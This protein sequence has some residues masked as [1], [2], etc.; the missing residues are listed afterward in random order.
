L[1]TSSGGGERARVSGPKAAKAAGSMTPRKARRHDMRQPR[2]SDRAAGAPKFFRRGPER[3][4]AAGGCRPHGARRA[5]ARRDLTFSFGGF[6]ET[7]AP[8]AFDK[9]LPIL[10]RAAI[11]EAVLGGF[12]TL[13]TSTLSLCAA[14]MS[15]PFFSFLSSCGRRATYAPRPVFLPAGQTPRR[16]AKRMPPPKKRGRK[17]RP[18]R[19]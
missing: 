15:I 6:L 13:S 18:E 3:Q 2:P 17:T 11:S 5:R 8:C 10:N 16:G 19:A 7:W 14:P 1:T 12:Q 9:S 4:R